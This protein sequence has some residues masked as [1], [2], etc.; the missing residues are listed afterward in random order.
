MKKITIGI[1]DDNKDFCEVVED[2]LNRQGN[3]DVIFTAED[4]L[5]AIDLLESSETCPDILILDLIMPHMD[6]FGVL[7][8]LGTKKLSKYPRI[9]ISLRI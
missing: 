9:I 5:K 8:H 4:G 6:G 1:V 3:M 2:Y 7:E